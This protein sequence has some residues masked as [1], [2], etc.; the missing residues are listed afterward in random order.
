MKMRRNL[1]RD[2]QSENVKVGYL[3]GGYTSAIMVAE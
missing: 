3:F 1:N 2:R